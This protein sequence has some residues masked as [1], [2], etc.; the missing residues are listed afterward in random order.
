MKKRLV[1]ILLLLGLL[2]ALLSPVLA[3]DDLPSGSVSGYVE[4]SP[5]TGL[6]QLRSVEEEEA[7]GVTAPWRAVTYVSSAQ[8]ADQLRLAM[9]AHQETVS[10]HVK[11]G[12]REMPDGVLSWFQNAIVSRAYSMELAKTPYDGDYLLMSL[13]AYRVSIGYQGDYYDLTVTVRYRIDSGPASQVPAGVTALAQSLGLSGMEPA[14]ACAAIYYSIV[15]N[16]SYDNAALSRV[17]DGTASREDYQIYSAYGALFNKKAVCQGYAMLFY[18][19]CREAGL[20]VRIITGPDHAWNIV[21]LGPWWYSLDCTWDSETPDYWFWFLRGSVNFASEHHVPEQP[22]NTREFQRDHPLSAYDFEYGCLYYDVFRRDW[23]Y[24]AVCQATEQGLFN[25]TGLRTFSPGDPVSRAMLVTVLWRMEG[26]PAPHVSAGFSDVP[27]GTWYTQ[28]VDWAAE[29]GVVNGVGGG[30]FAPND[31]ANRE[32]L[33]TVLCR[34]AAAK[35]ENT[36]SGGWDATF[37]DLEQVSPW[38]LESMQWATS[39]GIVSG[40]DNHCLG[41]GDN[42]SRAQYAAIL[43]RFL[44]ACPSVTQS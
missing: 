28:A 35:G 32:Q 26:A 11:A 3:L 19:L 16:V 1:S 29:N 23:Y 4:F 14:E 31:P 12:S 42:A 6:P 9:M 33:V 22:F 24:S 17:E 21:R 36:E 37:C 34:F 13:Q 8:A 41:P 40:Y 7:G 20:P 39:A 27:A 25:G 18:A 10:L 15:H 43:I 30:R 5:D 44:T 2:S 38:A